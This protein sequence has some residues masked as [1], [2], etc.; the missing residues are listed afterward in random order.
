MLSRDAVRI[1]P[2]TRVLFERWGGTEPL[3]GSVRVVEPVG[4]TKVSALGVDEQR[5]L[6]IADI[7]SPPEAW[8]R[9]G[10]G[11]RVEARFVLWEGEDVLKVP[12]SALFRVDEGWA[13]FR[14]DKDKAQMRT[15]EIGHR[16]G[17]ET[18][19]L[20]GLEER[21]AVIPHPSDAIVDGVAVEVRDGNDSP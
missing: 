11:Y 14:V 20:N 5:V 12:T 15:V 3:E 21:T 18:E 9:L 1:A 17:L 8:S 4:F 13:L 16:S 19:I 7:S 6:V 10:D 2:G